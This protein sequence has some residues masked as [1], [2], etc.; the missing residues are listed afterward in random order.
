[1]GAGVVGF[2]T[3]ARSVS[4][5]DIMPYE[6]GE[7]NGKGDRVAGY[8]LLVVGWRTPLCG[9]PSAREQAL[10]PIRLRSGQALARDNPC[11]GRKAGDCRAALAMT[12]SEQTA[13][14]STQWSVGYL[15]SSAFICGS[16]F[17]PG[18]LRVPASGRE[19][20]EVRVGQGPTHW[21]PASAGMT[22]SESA[23][24]RIHPSASLRACPEPVEGT[25]FAVPRRSQCPPASPCLGVK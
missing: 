7:G 14:I 3:F 12:G 16:S 5:G 25:A 22:W 6:G 17:F 11:P 2:R 24:V 21:I 9:S 19:M 20:I 23:S 13:V 8:S 18:I 1:M 4:L 10:R 15:R